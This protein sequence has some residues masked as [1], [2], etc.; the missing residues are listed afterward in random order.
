MYDIDYIIFA[1]IMGFLSGAL[2]MWLIKYIQKEEE[3]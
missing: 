1:A 3:K 2:I